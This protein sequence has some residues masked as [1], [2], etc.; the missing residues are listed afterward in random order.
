LIEGKVH[1][2]VVHVVLFHFG[3]GS[4]VSVPVLVLLLRDLHGGKECV[5]LRIIS[6]PVLHLH[7]LK[8]SVLLGIHSDSFSKETEMVACLS[9]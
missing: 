1:G 4:F 8:V 9:W 7:S 3:S 6:E 2:L 5:R